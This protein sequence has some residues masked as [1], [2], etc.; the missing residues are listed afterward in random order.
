VLARVRTN[1]IYVEI[2]GIIPAALIQV[3]RLEYGHRLILRSEWGERMRNVLDAPL[4]KRE[5]LEMNPGAYL[6]FFRL[7]NGL[8]QMGLG[9]TL[10]MSRQNVS[11]M[12]NGRRPI[13]RQMALRLSRF[14]AVSADKFIG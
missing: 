2:K 13:S 8:S 1:L 6:R 3:L 5:P 4:Y 10:G 11:H 12:E 9:Q 14:F 7:D